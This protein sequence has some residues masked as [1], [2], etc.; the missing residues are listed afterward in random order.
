MSFAQYQEYK[1]TGV[2]WLGK[3]P[4][5]WEIVP[6][7]TI[8]RRVKRT[9]FINEEPLSVYRDHGVVPKSSRDDNHNRLS[10]DLTPYQLVDV[11]DLVINKMKAFQGSVAISNYRGIV[12]PAYFVYE[13]SHSNNPRYLHYL[14]RSPRYVF[15]YLSISK[16]IRPNQWDIDPQEHS[17]LPLV[18]P[19]I[20]EQ[21]VIADFLDDQIMSLEALISE[22][23]KLI[24]LSIER[25]QAIIYQTVT[26]GLDQNVVKKKTDIDWLKEIPAKW[27]LSKV[28]YLFHIGRGRVIAQEIVEPEGLYPVYSSQTLN[29]GCL[30]YID[31]FDFDCEQLTWTT[32]GANA[33]TVFLRHGKHNCTNVC[34]TLLPKSKDFNLKYLHLWLTFATQFYKR[35][36]TNGAKIMNSEM[37]EIFVLLPS[38]DEQDSIAQF[39]QIEVSKFDALIAE[40][41]KVIETLQE[42]R[43]T[44]ISEAVLGQIDVRNYKYKEAA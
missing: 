16:G 10:E 22:Q 44:L 15:S 37:A 18:L 35:P 5:H 25:R 2:S 30:G 20:I 17:R 34:G 28:K 42:R 7:W 9:G 40:S 14:M 32:D 36:D 4:S 1:D 29:D 12:S 33:G 31:T 11:D 6:L 27:E 24:E 23:E 41:R 21:K 26:K 13:S 39:L 19:P 3:I 38:R 43:T 8:F